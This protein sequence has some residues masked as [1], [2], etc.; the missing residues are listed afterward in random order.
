MNKFFKLFLI[1]TSLLLIFISCSN[2]T[3][4]QTETS[5]K[6][7]KVTKPLNFNL[8]NAKA[9]ASVENNKSE[10]SRAAVTADTKLIKVLDDSTIVEALSLP[11]NI[12]LSKISQII[13]REQNNRK[14][15]YIIFEGTS[16]YTYTETTTYEKTI[17]ITYEPDD[18]GN[19]KE[20]EIKTEIYTED[21]SVSGSLGQL[22]CVYEDGSYVDI[23]KNEDETINSISNLDFISFDNSANIYY[24]DNNNTICKFSPMEKKNNTLT[25][26]VEGTYYDQFQISQ[27]GA[28]IFVSG[29]RNGTAFIR[30]IPINNPDNFENMYYS[31]NGGKPC[32]WVYQDST[33]YFYYLS[34]G[35]ND[36][37]GLYRI[38]MLNGKKECLNSPD[39]LI[40]GNSTFK[41]ITDMGTINS[42]GYA[43]SSSKIY[44]TNS[45]IWIKSYEL[46]DPFIHLVD[47]NGVYLGY[48]YSGYAPCDIISV[49]NSF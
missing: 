19:I 29:N 41:L 34:W 44:N 28:K 20:P 33:D 46:K 31:S 30:F 35:H 25:A 11:S 32:K 5:I 40:N 13:K 8:S 23:L 10:S 18:D 16:S 43:S 14:Y 15:L 9:I 2:G 27:D 37:F 4:S 26:T 38:N 21:K 45:G 1:F 49:D 6:I 36:E 24:I 22:L 48:T 42:F 12:T 17:T 39:E 47:E 3:N 7:L